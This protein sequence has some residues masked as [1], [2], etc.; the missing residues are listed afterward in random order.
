[1][2]CQAGF[3]QWLTT[4]MQPLSPL[5]K[6]QAT[7]LAL[8]SFGRGLARAGALTAVSRL[9]AE[10]MQRS[11]QTV[12]QRWRAWEDDTQRQRGPKRQALRVETWFAPC[13]GWGVSGWQGTPL[14][15]A[16][17]ATPLGQ[18]LVV[19]AVSVVYRG[20]AIP[21]AGVILPAGAKH[22]WRRAWLCGLHR[23]HPAS[24][25]AGR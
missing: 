7:V 2:F 11:K 10:G 4:I 22:A 8:W 18:R 23:L 12:R 1:M 14:A 19:L 15:L 16:L 24:R 17:E 9:L 3:D 21:V 25:R 13:L 5:S 20:W 6:P